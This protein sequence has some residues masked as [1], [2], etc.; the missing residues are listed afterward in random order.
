MSGRAIS[1]AELASLRSFLDE[2]DAG[3]GEVA[4]RPWTVK[5]GGAPWTF[6]T[7]GLV[8]LALRGTYA[9]PAGALPGMV[10]QVRVW[11]DAE[12]A[13]TFAARRQALLTWA[14]PEG[15]FVGEAR[16]GSSPGWLLG[17]LVD[18]VLLERLLLAVGDDVVH[19]HIPS[20]RLAMVRLWGDSWRALL[21]PM[22]DGDTNHPRFPAAL[23]LPL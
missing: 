8:A 21:M 7:N 3:H 13:P 14:N 6:A 19:V 20:N 10:E 16:W 4:S 22:A 5:L 2:E 12:F 17:T 11:L 23:E 18:R 9:R 15:K 1:K